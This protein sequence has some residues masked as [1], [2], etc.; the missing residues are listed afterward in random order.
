M[1][2]DTSTQS[3]NKMDILILVKV[4]Y[5]RNV[6]H[7]KGCDKLGEDFK[8][9]KKSCRTPLGHICMSAS[10]QPSGCR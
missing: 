6:K 2:K 1:E 7:T 9:G 5:D 8:G 4:K 3:N 10:L